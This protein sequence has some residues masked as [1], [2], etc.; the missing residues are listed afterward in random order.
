MA[1]KVVGKVKSRAIL[2][3]VPNLTDDDTGKKKVSWLT[4]EDCF[5]LTTLAHGTKIKKPQKKGAS[6]KTLECQS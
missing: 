5:F 2:V 1:I 4:H 3:D 6:V